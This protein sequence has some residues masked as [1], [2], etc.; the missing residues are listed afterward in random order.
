MLIISKVFRPYGRVGSPTPLKAYYAA[1][2]N[3]T[4]L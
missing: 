4:A 2:M 1:E 3:S